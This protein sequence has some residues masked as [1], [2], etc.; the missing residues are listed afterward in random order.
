M[1]VVPK[2]TADEES[3]YLAMK[4]ERAQHSRLGQG[5]SAHPV[6]A[7][8]SMRQCRSILHPSWWH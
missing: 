4:S 5:G 2:K 6:E 7:V 8:G 3:D 1:E